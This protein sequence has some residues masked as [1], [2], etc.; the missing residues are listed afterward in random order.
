VD[1]GPAVVGSN[2][3]VVPEGATGCRV[4]VVSQFPYWCAGN[5]GVCPCG[6][7][8]DGSNGAA[9]CR[10][11]SHAGGGAL[12]AGGSGSMALSD[13][14]LIGSGLPAGA[15]GVFFQGNLA[16]NNG[17]GYLFGD[18]LRCAGQ[19]VRRLEIVVADAAGVAASSVPVAT[20]GGVAS[21]VTR[22]Y[23]LW[24]SD[25]AGSPCGLGFNT[26]NAISVNWAP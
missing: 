9:G 24:Y 11:G 1:G 18:G 22:Y 7:E 14:V 19:A 25:A 5:Q 17:Q 21:G 8:N 10:N 23:Q 4:T 20:A 15:A 3:Q 16:L 2:L 13:L 26:T 6:N 12:T